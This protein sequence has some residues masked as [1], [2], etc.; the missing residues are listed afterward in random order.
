MLDDLSTVENAHVPLD[1]VNPA[2]LATW[3][4][5]F[6]TSVASCVSTN[7]VCAVFAE[8]RH[9][10]KPSDLILLLSKIVEVNCQRI[11]ANGAPEHFIWSSTIFCGI[12]LCG[13]KGKVNVMRLDS[14]VADMYSDVLSRI[15][16][17]TSTEILYLIRIGVYIQGYQNRLLRDH[18]ERLLSACAWQLDAT[19]LCRC[20]TALA[21]SSNNVHFVKLIG[22]VSLSRFHDLDAPQ[23]LMIFRALSSARQ[24][25]T[26]F[27]QGAIRYAMNPKIFVGQDI[28]SVLT[29][30]ARK[31]SACTPSL[32]ES[33]LE[34]A[35]NLDLT[36][37]DPLDLCG[38]IWATCKHSKSPSDI[39]QRAEDLIIEYCPSLPAR[40]ISMLLWAMAECGYTSPELLSALEMAAIRASESM[41]TSNVALC[42]QSIANLKEIGSA[43][44]FHDH[45][46]ADIIANA[47]HFNG[48]DLAMLAFGY[49]K[50]G[51]GSATLHQCIQ[52]CALK[53]AE[54]LPADCL[55]KLLWAYGR[56]GGR[57]SLFTGLQF[58]MLQRVNQ[59]SVHELCRVLWA[60]AVMRFYDVGFWRNCISMLPV[61]HVRD[62]PHCAILYPSLSEVTTVRKDLLNSDTLR[63]LNHTKLFFMNEEL[64]R[65][66]SK[67]ADRISD[68]LQSIGIEASSQHDFKGFLLDSYFEY[69]DQ[70]Y[71]V[72]VYSDHN[73]V[74]KSLRPSGE[75]ILKRRF[76]CRHGLKILHVLREPFLNLNKDDA[77]AVLSKQMQ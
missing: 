7:D 48:L 37:I 55:A 64:S 9:S 67:T 42:V 74:G 66:C 32:L 69:G 30:Y 24:A 3:K 10:L 51:M 40:S 70:K 22:H 38:L 63:L 65:Y 49:S 31:P 1:R 47:S 41:T 25:S 77:S 68:A 36:Q 59:F 29:C 28:V 50:L 58:H 53:Y 72:L 39:F 56:V 61:E 52:E 14:G 60:Y 62:N 4:P 12:D 19:D 73:T 5:D 75:M 26:L 34:R 45:V 13:L 18:A 27:L 15:H 71:G 16:A 17:F 44:E 20:A 8:H 21:E 35:S 54:D 11:E 46:E 2:D 6:R 33:L 23:R 43:S 76:L 57:E